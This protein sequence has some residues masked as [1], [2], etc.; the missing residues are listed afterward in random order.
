MKRHLIKSIA[1]C[2]LMSLPFSFAHAATTNYLQLSYNLTHHTN[3]SP[4][5]VEMAF[6]G[7]QWALKSNKVT[8]KDIITIVDFTV[9]SAKDRL[10]VI[11]LKSGQILMAMPVAHGKGSGKSSPWA[12]SF[13][14]KNDSLKSSLGVFL[15]QNT[16]FGKHGFSLRIRGLET[17]NNHAAARDVVVHSANYVTPQFIKSH[18]YAGN[19]WGCF[20]VAPKESKQLINYIGKGSVLYAYGQSN[21]YMASTKI[22]SNPGA[23]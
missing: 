9:S 21:Q 22:L 19:S 12:T 16:Y 8:N 15:T 17:S 5:A 3:L 10:Y 4:K 11:N 20:A 6:A 23:A 7:Y 14:N 13:S 18:G 1:V 2:G